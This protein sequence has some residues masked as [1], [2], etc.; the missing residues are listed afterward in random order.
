MPP[1]KPRKFDIFWAELDP[2]QGGEIKKTRP[3]IIVSPDVTNQR[4][5][6]VTIVPMTTKVKDFPFRLNVKLANGDVGQIIIEQVR[7]IDRSRLKGYYG[8]LA[9][10][11]HDALEKELVLFFT[12][13]SKE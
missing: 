12:K 1:E 7:T 3:C 10:Q 2:T 6:I 8:R 5:R 9:D 13:R 4:L 11:F